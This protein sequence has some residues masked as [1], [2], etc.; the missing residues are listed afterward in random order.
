MNELKRE[1]I[2]G[3]MLYV[4]DILNTSSE[5]IVP[6]EFE[7][8]IVSKAHNV[9]FTGETV[10]LPGVVSRKKQIAPNIEKVLS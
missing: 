5:V 2:D 10:T 9:E 4:V 6:S 7:R 3:V 1:G 8:D